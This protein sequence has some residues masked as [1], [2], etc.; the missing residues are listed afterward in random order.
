VAEWLGRGLQSLVHQFES[1]R[2]LFV[3]SLVAFLIAV[4][5]AFGL[6]RDATSSAVA[7]SACPKVSAAAKLPFRPGGGRLRGDVDGDGRLDRISIRYAPQARASCGFLLVVE[8]RSRAFAVR[9]P[10]WYKAP[11]D[12]R[13]R[14]WTFPE[15]FLAAVVRLEARRAQLVVARSHGASV[16]S[17]SL[18]G[19]VGGRLVQLRFRPRFYQD[20]LS[21]FGTAGTGDANVR[22]IPGGP[23]V[24]LVRQPHDVDGRQW[25]VYRAEYRLRGSTFVRVRSRSLIASMNR[26]FAVAHRWGMDAR[27]FTGCTVAR[28][29]RL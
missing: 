2:R 10:E 11:Q 24:F 9:V 25:S 8:T 1:G 15:P 19:I 28:G 29:K 22:C 18:H 16:A 3:R 6:S 13:I 27:P 12:L 26:A 4:A 7:V 17:V 14:D 23:L 5:F 21:L 20:E